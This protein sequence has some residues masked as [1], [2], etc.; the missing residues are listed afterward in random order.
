VPP[1]RTT[2]MSKS[3]RETWHQ[4]TDLAE[5]GTCGYRTRFMNARGR[6][7]VLEESFSLGRAALR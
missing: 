5:F 7:F 3:G 6:S 1:F 2:S 4:K